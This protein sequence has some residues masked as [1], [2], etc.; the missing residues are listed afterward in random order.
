MDRPAQVAHLRRRDPGLG[1]PALRRQR[2][3]AQASSR[4]PAPRTQRPARARLHGEVTA[5]SMS[6]AGV[7]RS[8]RFP[9]RPLEQVDVAR[10]LRPVS[11]PGAIV[12]GRGS[13]RTGRIPRGCGARWGGNR[14]PRVRRPCARGE[15]TVAGR[16]PPLF[17]RWP[18]A[19]WPRKS[20]AGDRDRLA[21]WPTRPPGK[22]SS[23]CRAGTAPVR[24]GD[25][26]V[27]RD[28]GVMTYPPV[29][30]ASAGRR[31]AVARWARGH[32]RPSGRS[33][34]R[35]RARCGARAWA[36]ARCRA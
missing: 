4:P 7:A 29:V 9:A 30:S 3:K 6:A 13:L 36:A 8:V 22:W 10:L 14:A 1:R 17:H 24:L 35:P 12:P 23:V 16:P 15:R 2:A 5:A 25:R 27:G 20:G 18:A 21:P 11:A 33:G 28:L 32:V 19:P 34:A 26:T 31:Q